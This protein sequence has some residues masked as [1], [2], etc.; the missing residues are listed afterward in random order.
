MNKYDCIIVGGGISG[1]L[2]ALV[3]SKEGILADQVD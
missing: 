1:L 3:L 2:S